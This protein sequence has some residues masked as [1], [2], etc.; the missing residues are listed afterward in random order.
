LAPNTPAPDPTAPAFAADAPQRFALATQS[1]LA[2][3]QDPHL[4]ATLK[5]ASAGH[6]LHAIGSEIDLSTG[7]MAHQ[8]G[9]LVLDCAALATPAA[10]LAE[11]L[12][13]QFPDLVL[14]VAGRPDEQGLL[15]AQISSGVVYR[16]LHK[17]FSEQRA[18]LFVEAAWRRHDETI[19]A[20][21]HPAA[22]RGRPQ[23]RKSGR[24]WLWLLALAAVAAPLVWFALETN[25]QPSAGAAPPAPL[26]TAPADTAL[27]QLLTRADQARAAGQLLTPPGNNA[28]DLYREALQRDPHEQR[29]LN[30][31]EAV[32]DKLLADADAQLQQHHLDAAQQ[33]VDAARTLSP[34]H[35]HVAFLAA[36]IGAQREHAALARTLPASPASQPAVRQGDARVTDFLTKARAA[37]SSGALIEPVEDNARFYIESARELAADDPQVQQA[38][39]DLIARLEGE[40]RK[41]I[42]AKNLDQ[43]EIWTA[44]AADVGANPGQVAALR[45]DAAQLRSSAQADAMARL[46]Q[47]FKERLEQGRIVEPATDSA[48]FYLGQLQ[49]ADTGG[50]ATLQARSAYAARA[51]LEAHTTLQAQDFAAT[52]RWLD[53]ARAAG[54]DAAGVGTVAAALN[55]A[56][57]EAQANDSYVNESTLTR[58]RY[59]PPQFPT[60]AREKG[61]DGWV[62]LQFLVGSDG[63]VSDVAVVGA[64]PVGIFEQAA[65]DAVRHWRYQAVVRDG[66][67]VSQR[68]RVRVRFAVQR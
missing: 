41:S 23:H 19:I 22:A 54:A 25:E 43:A 33:L 2:F 57:G 16:F 18:R 56:Q 5:N 11:R 29:A 59:V 13:K 40:A 39:A 42:D 28:A 44:A 48:K 37:L 9:V 27:A 4:L 20:P 12:H 64:Q 6:A 32:I 38:M 36:Q 26:N 58:T 47:S 30:G 17:P 55:A 15:A 31:L 61:I 46:S 45:E 62:D 3:T 49:Q 52:R 67:K 53:E 7:L 63:V 35:P 65:Q 34:A 50:Q 24:S 60:A 10:A 8:A 66:Q 68:A 21:R 51:L 1:L 14:V